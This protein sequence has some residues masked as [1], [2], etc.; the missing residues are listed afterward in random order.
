MAAQQRL[1][2]P[3]AA[4]LPNRDGMMTGQSVLRIALPDQP[5]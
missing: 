3:R 1:F 4:V 2:A 5:G